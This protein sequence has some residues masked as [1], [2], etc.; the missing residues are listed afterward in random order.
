MDE[1]IISKKNENVLN[2]DFISNNKRNQSSAARNELLD[3]NLNNEKK[4][5]FS[6]ALRD[7]TVCLTIDAR[8]EGVK[9]PDRL[10]FRKD[11]RLNFC[12]EFHLADFNFNDEGVWATLA[13]MPEGDFFCFIPWAAVYMA[14]SLV[15]SKAMVWTFT[16]DLF[17]QRTNAKNLADEGNM[18]NVIPLVFH[19]PE[20]KA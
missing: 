8:M 14:H 4:T 16:E 2:V 19:K 13:F 1:K 20:D 7:G 11:L 17:T 12:Y 15:S 5:F 10:K 6:T 3:K 9:V 18:K